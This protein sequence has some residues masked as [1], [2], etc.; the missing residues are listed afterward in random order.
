MFLVEIRWV[1]LKLKMSQVTDVAEKEFQ[2]PMADE[3]TMM[4]LS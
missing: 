2:E 4:E 3:V 1:V